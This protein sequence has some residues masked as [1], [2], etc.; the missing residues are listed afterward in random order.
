[1]FLPKTNCWKFLLRTL[2]DAMKFLEV[3]KCLGRSCNQLDSSSQVTDN[4]NLPQ[5]GDTSKP[6]RRQ[7]RKASSSAFYMFWIYLLTFDGYL[8]VH[9][10]NYTVLKMIHCI[11]YPYGK[12]HIQRSQ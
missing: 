4:I 10:Q 6:C 2:E 3:R 11:Q 5:A 9:F 12:R 8:L 7:R 1:M